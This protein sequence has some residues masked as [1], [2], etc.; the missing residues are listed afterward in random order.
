MLTL[1]INLKIVLHI[2]S[3]N[4]F[5]FK[6]SINQSNWQNLRDTQK[7]SHFTS[8]GCEISFH[9]STSSCQ[10][11]NFRVESENNEQLAEFVRFPFRWV[12][13]HQLTTINWRWMRRSAY[14]ADRQAGNRK[15]GFKSNE[16]LKF[17]HTIAKK[18]AL[19]AKG[20]TVNDSV[21]NLHT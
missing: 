6:R 1:E 21:N 20:C 17:H 14:G 11:T 7:G 8:L 10:K 18:K 2:D 3:L 15:K 9:F 5:L 4:K 19:T 13:P 12:F 16:I